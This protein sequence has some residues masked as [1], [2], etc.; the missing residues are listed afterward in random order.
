[1]T[2]RV[3]M[4]QT[5]NGSPEGTHTYSYEVGKVYEVTDRLG[6]VFCEWGF[7][8]LDTGNEDTFAT[9]GGVEIPE[10]EDERRRREEAANGFTQP[11]DLAILDEDHYPE[12]AEAIVQAKDEAASVV[13]DAPAAPVDELPA[14][15]S[16]VELNAAAKAIGV[17]ASKLRNKDAVRAAIAAAQGQ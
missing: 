14:D 17:D 4:L 16:R 3:R 8:E 2:A 5:T 6:E 12:H 13:Q 1:M 9:P 11:P 10:T 15:L 7:A